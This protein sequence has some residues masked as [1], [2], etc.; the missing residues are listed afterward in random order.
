MPF[1][2]LPFDYQLK[3]IGW[4]LAGVVSF[5]FLL[6]RRRRWKSSMMKLRFV[7]LLL[8]LWTFLA[9]FTVVE[10]YFAVIFDQ[11]D[12]FNMTM[13]SEK[14][15]IR[16][17]KPDQKILEFQNGDN[18]TYRDD[19]KFPT[20]I[21]PTQHHI[22]FVGDSFT[23]G[24]GVP[25]VSDRFSNRVA[26]SLEREHPGRFIVSNLAD[27]GRDTH[28]VELILQMLTSSNYRVDTFVYVVCLNDIETFHERWKTYYADLASH[29]PHFFLCHESYF[30]NF[31]YF[32]LK[33]FSVPDIHE[34]YSFVKEYYDGEPWLRMQ[35]KLDEIHQLCRDHN[36]E[37]KIV[38]FPFMH[39]LGPDYDFHHAHTK[40][41]NYC[42]EAKIPVL[43]LEPVLAPHVEEGLT[44]SRFDAHPNERAHE[45]AA[46]AIREFLSVDLF[47]AKSLGKK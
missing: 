1:D 4:L 28:W 44:V 16:H 8:S 47:Q 3:M 13:V 22:C 24:H 11:T 41:V 42:R 27:A 37:L 40:L 19:R 36:I 30:L 33:M 29:Q 26:A 17:I 18:T 34:Y 10:L 35:R 46:E 15:F 2:Y 25:N 23:F 32:R 38:V 5:L 9:A 12:S 43:D 45:L 14:W 39:N 21:S 7:H 20:S 31:A 6:T